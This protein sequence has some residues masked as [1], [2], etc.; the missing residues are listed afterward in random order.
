MAFERVSLEFDGNIAVLKFN[1]PE[2]LNAIGG[3]MLGELT[4]AVR[5]VANPSNG[6]RCLLLNGEA[7]AFRR[8]RISRI[9]TAPR[10]RVPATVC[11]RVSPA[12]VAARPADADGDG[13]ERRCAR[14]RYEFR[15]DGG[16]SCARRR[17][18]FSCRRLRGSA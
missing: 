15:D 1:H 4:Q 17:T 5:E 3:Q 9:A 16:A 7:A 8:V 11:I 13:R 14:R 12:V 2:V 10:C 18:R 6:A